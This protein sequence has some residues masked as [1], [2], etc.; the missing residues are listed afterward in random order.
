MTYE[1][2]VEFLSSKMKM[3]HIYQP[4]LIRSLVDAGGSATPHKL[5]QFFFSENE[6]KL[7]I[8]EKRIK[9]MPINVLEKSGVASEDGALVHLKAAFLFCKTE[10]RS[11]LAQFSIWPRNVVPE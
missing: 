10:Y 9:E 5:A 8:C 7:L 4:L 2:L 3:S 11:K 6:S 1:Q